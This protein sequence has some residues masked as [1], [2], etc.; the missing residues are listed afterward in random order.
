MHILLLVSCIN[1]TYDL[2]S[3]A[4]IEYRIK[5]H[6]AHADAVV[7]LPYENYML[8]AVL[9]MILNDFVISIHQYMKAVYLCGYTAT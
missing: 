5:L 8:A 4:P 9:H 7:Q 1:H 2:K 6:A 3:V